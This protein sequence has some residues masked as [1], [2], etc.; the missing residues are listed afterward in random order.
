MAL[1]GESNLYGTSVETTRFQ[2]TGATPRIFFQNHDGTDT[3]AI[4]EPTVFKNILLLG[5]A[6]SGKTNVMNQIVDQT[7]V[8][9]RSRSKDGVAL[10]FDTKGD[11]IAHKNF[12]KPGDYIIGNDKRFRDVS[13]TWNIFDEVLADG[14][15]P[16]DYEPNA[17][18]IA[19]VLFKDRGSQTQPFFVNAARDIFANTIIYFIRRSKDNPEKWQGKLNNE[20]LVR[21][22]L[23]HTP[24]EFAKYFTI[25]E[26]MHGLITYIGDGKNNQALGVFGELR[27]MLYDC[28]QGIFCKSPTAAQ[29]SF[30]IRHAVREKKGRT[31]FI[32]YDMALGETMTPIY[33]LLVDLALKEAL[34]TSS[35]GHT[36]IF[37]DELKLLPKVTHL[38]DALNFGRS[39]HVSVVAG[40][41]NVGQIT[42]TYG[43]ETGRNIL[44]GF[45]SV[46]AMK[47]ND[48]ESREFVSKRF[49]PNLVAYRYEN[50]SSSPIDRERDGMVVEH[51]HIQ[52]LDTGHAVVGL[53][54]QKAPFFFYFE[55]DKDA[56]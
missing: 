4:D 18:E 42:S 31:I 37:L 14:N 55:E 24:E 36:H 20:L 27:L 25:Y 12:H 3:F 10:I 46:I 49:G 11:F 9:N 17:R 13:V 47:S 52:N 51:W 56:I 43:E 6:G 39:K 30:S 44:G 53:A 40:L 7:L 23:K 38:E 2:G 41:Q 8:W 1:I 29:P 28:F 33:R 21:F 22:L 16:K 54:S 5:G 50:R 34:S 48:Y 45:G 19:S 26:D 15:A 35:N 32:L